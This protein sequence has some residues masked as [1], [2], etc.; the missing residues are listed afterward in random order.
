MRATIYRIFESD[1]PI[2]EPIIITNLFYLINDN[3]LKIQSKKPSNNFTTCLSIEIIENQKKNEYKQKQNKLL[4]QGT[5]ENFK[6]ELE[7]FN[8][9]LVKDLLKQCLKLC[10][11]PGVFYICDCSKD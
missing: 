5:L 7:N 11:F 8:S 1:F 2:F 10:H 3:F 9:S 4:I 6:K